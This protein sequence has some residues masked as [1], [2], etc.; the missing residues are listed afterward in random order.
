MGSFTAA[1]RA[2]GGEKYLDGIRENAERWG[3]DTPLR[4]AHWLAQMAH[5]SGSF[6]YVKE[7]W[8]PTAQQLK[9][10]PPSPLARKLGNTELGDGLRFRGR[11]FIQ[12]TGRA[13]YTSCSIDLYGDRRLLTE[14]MLL[15][16]DPAASAGWYWH[17]RGI[18]KHADRD[19]IK[20]VTKAIN[21]GYNGLADR[22][23]RLATAKRA[24]GL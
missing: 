12:V 21:G 15:E 10:E 23:A 22:Q 19:D 5:E 8:G 4:Q 2:L 1:V 13:N 16:L 9:Y 6:R 7:I 11:G 24:L 18:N 14:P 20:A 17:M 3:I